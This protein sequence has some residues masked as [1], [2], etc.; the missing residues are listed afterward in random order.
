MSS[1]THDERRHPD[2]EALAH[3]VGEAHARHG[4]EPRAH[5]L[6][7]DQRHEDDDEHPQQL[8]AVARARGGVRRDAAGVVAGVRGD[9]ARTED[10]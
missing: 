4:A 5:L 9:Q 8:V 10:A 3:E 1:A 7:D 6:H 2:A